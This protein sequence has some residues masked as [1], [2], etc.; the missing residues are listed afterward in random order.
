MRKRGAWIFIASILANYVYGI[1]IIVNYKTFPGEALFITGEGE[2]L[3]DWKKATRLFNLSE[4][5][6]EFEKNEIKT[7]KPFKI[8]KASFDLGGTTTDI[9]K[10]TWQATDNIYTTKGQMYL[11]PRFLGDPPNP[12]WT[13]TQSDNIPNVFNNIVQILIPGLSPTMPAYNPSLVENETHTGY[14]LF[15]R[16]DRNPTKR[17]REAMI[18]VVDLDQDF[19]LLQ[20]ARYRNIDTIKIKGGVSSQSEDPRIIQ[21]Q[22]TYYIFYNDTQIR[23]TYGSRRDMYMGELNPRTGDITHVVKLSY[24]N[25]LQDPLMQKN[26][27]P[28]VQDEK[29]RL[30]YSYAPFIVLEPDRKTGV[31][32]EVGNVLREVKWEKTKG[33]VRG[34]SQ[35]LPIPGSSNEFFTFFHSSGNFSQSSSEKQERYYLIGALRFSVNE[36]KRKY[37]ITG[38]SHSPLLNPELYGQ[39]KNPGKIVFV[40]GFVRTETQYVLSLGVNDD[41]I[42]L[43]FADKESIEGN[44]EAPFNIPSPSIESVLPKMKVF[45]RLGE[46]QDANQAIREELRKY[47]RLVDAS[48]A[49]E[50]IVD[51]NL[52]LDGEMDPSQLENGVE[53]WIMLDA[54]QEEIKVPQGR[55]NYFFCQDIGCSDIETR[56]PNLVVFKLHSESMGLNIESVS[57]GYDERQPKTI[58]HAVYI[59]LDA[60]DS[61]AGKRSYARRNF[62][63]AQSLR[64]HFPLV[65]FP[66]INGR[67]WFEGRYDPKGEGIQTLHYKNQLV[68]YEYRKEV[69]AAKGMTPAELGIFLSDYEI[70]KEAVENRYPVTLLLEDDAELP[71]FFS[72]KL[73][74]LMSHIP[75][76]W[77][78]LYLFTNRKESWACNESK[79]YRKTTHGLFRMLRGEA[80]IPG[81]VAAIFSQKGA[82]KLY[83]EMQGTIIQPADMIVADLLIPQKKG[84]FVIFATEPDLVATETGRFDSVI[85]KMGRDH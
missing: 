64:E 77:D 8:V 22:N 78:M 1:D 28:F 69:H 37:E 54:R 24:P 84:E 35:A 79:P 9:A 76:N 38:I 11:L 52:F 10:W 4:Y 83:R 61:E 49:K 45:S 51:V 31:C 7:G 75:K 29:I 57:K 70:L 14:Y 6:W 36:S 68:Q 33:Q 65:R 41:K 67:K 18:G 20:G 58:S 23:Y 85:K 2:A 60:T 25:A 56:Y 40:S 81:M 16:Y 73:S 17:N 63:E 55:G 44:M 82:R 71:L 74:R 62:M 5:L 80:C 30:V 46:S 47:F 53:N 15:F 21:Y 59:N 43:A 48:E 72:A 39:E 66:A 3:G 42:Y 27:V 13:Y 50:E 19:H 26:W 34:G 12:S 32:R